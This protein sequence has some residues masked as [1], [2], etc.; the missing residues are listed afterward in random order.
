MCQKMANAAGELAK[1]KS[2]SSRTSF[3]KISKHSTHS[4]RSNSAS[5]QSINAKKKSRVNNKP[6]E[7]KDSTGSFPHP[8]PKIVVSYFTYT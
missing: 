5:K 4:I 3:K 8:I 6:L 7:N 2:K 1:K